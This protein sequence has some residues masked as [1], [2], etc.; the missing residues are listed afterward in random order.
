MRCCLAAAWWW[1][2]WGARWGAR[3][4]QCTRRP[5]WAEEGGRCRI[6]CFAAGSRQRLRGH[7]EELGPRVPCTRMRCRRGHA[8]H[9]HHAAREWVRQGEGAAARESAVTVLPPRTPLTP[10]A[11]HPPAGW[12]SPHWSRTLPR[13]GGGS[14]RAGDVD[15]NPHAC[16]GTPERTSLLQ[17]EVAG[18]GGRPA[19]ASGAAAAGGHGGVQEGQARAVALVLVLLLR[20]ARR[21]EGR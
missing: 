2:E 1:G 14:I 17:V 11:S 10:S 3:W 15:Q 8:L 16:M 4:G 20:L 5:A 6:S 12:P 19:T 9:T 7:A 13:R 21:G 18:G